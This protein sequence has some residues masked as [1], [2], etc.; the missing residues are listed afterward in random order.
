[1]FKTYEEYV[2]AREAQDRVLS[3]F[4]KLF[5]S[6][7]QSPMGG[8]ADEARKTAKYQK[9][10]KEWDIE[11]KKYQDMNKFASKHFKKEIKADQLKKRS[12]WRK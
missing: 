12:A 2:Q 4:E 8:V 11:F 1:M 7:P 9:V 6:F 5:K 10:K 3:V